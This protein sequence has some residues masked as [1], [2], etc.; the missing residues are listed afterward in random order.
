M[1]YLV[2]LGDAKTEINELVRQGLEIILNSENAVP[3][4]IIQLCATLVLFL[5]VRF[6]LWGK[7]TKVIQ[8]KEQNEK[9]AFENL[10]KAKSEAEEIR[11]QIVLEEENAKEEGYKIIERAKQ[12]S[13]L[14]AE[15]IIK[16]AQIDA[17]MKLEDA[18]EEINKEIAKANDDIKKEIIEI[19]YMLASKIIDEEIDKS[20]YDELVKDF[21]KENG[22]NNDWCS[23]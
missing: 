11:K 23:Y 2:M 17:N 22:V 12:K 19:A 18:K 4:I 21:M 14:E 8:E 7:I 6:L 15:E 16:K 5:A 13:Y 10:E 3:S 9:E 20:K 1:N